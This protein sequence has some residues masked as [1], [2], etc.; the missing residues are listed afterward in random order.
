MRGLFASILIGMTLVGHEYGSCGMDKLSMPPWHTTV[1]ETAVSD[2]PAFAGCDKAVDA[3]AASAKWKI[4]DRKYFLSNDWG[5]LLRA[6]VVFDF[7]GSSMT[8]LVNCWSRK[9]PD[10]HFALRA[11]DARW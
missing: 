5:R 4:A 3:L 7:K 10:V 2:S 1:G 6:K 11:Q 8:F 9:D